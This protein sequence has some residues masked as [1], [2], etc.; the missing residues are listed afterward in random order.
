MHIKNKT[1]KQNFEKMALKKFQKENN[2]E[3]NEFMKQST[4]NDGHQKENQN[5]LE[6]HFGCSV[7]GKK[8]RQ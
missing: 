3:K 1:Q 5:K 6:K 2:V 4:R 7:F 8:N